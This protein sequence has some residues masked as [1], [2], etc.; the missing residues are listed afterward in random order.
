M[1]PQYI[2]ESGACL[3]ATNVSCTLGMLARYARSEGCGVAALPVV[4]D[5]CMSSPYI[6]HSGLRLAATNVF[7]T[8]GLSAM[9]A[10]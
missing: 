10:R 3:A 4:W 7:C 2:F 8:F 9:Y 6:F 1:S 5:V